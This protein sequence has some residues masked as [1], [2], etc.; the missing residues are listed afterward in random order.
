MMGL[1]LRM[2]KKEM[3][4]RR[5]RRGLLHLH[6]LAR[7]FIQKVNQVKNMVDTTILSRRTRRVVFNQR[8][9]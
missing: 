8:N 2:K 9:Y 6:P 7:R 5:L 1:V 3:E 4:Q